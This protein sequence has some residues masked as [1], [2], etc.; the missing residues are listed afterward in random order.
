MGWL[1]S[2]MLFIVFFDYQRLLRETFK[3]HTV[4]LRCMAKMT[5]QEEVSRAKSY[6]LI[7]QQLRTTPMDRFDRANAERMLKFYARKQ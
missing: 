7:Y 5:I 2:L 1:L 3:Y 6:G 4:L